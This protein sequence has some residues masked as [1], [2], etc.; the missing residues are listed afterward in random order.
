MKYG[1][2]RAITWSS[3]LIDARAG[4][5]RARQDVCNRDETFGDNNLPGDELSPAHLI[6]QVN[7]I[8]KTL[9]T[10]K[11]RAHLRSKTQLGPLL[12]N[13]TRRSSTA[14]MV[15]RFLKFHDWV[16]DLMKKIYRCKLFIWD[17]GSKGF[18]CNIQRNRYCHCLSGIWWSD[19]VQPSICSLLV[20]QSYRKVWR[21]VS[22]VSVPK[23]RFR[24]TMHFEQLIMLHHNKHLWGINSVNVAGE[25]AHVQSKSSRGITVSSLSSSDSDS[26]S[27]DD[28]NDQWQTFLPEIAL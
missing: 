2:V 7:D 9:R 27:G 19:R 5:C 10:L 22:D 23:H 1:V 16:P 20:R 15:F 14:K 18:G 25:K 4:D 24:I 17:H 28:V 3:D 11:L 26:V 6:D 13:A 21:T 8:M 12:R